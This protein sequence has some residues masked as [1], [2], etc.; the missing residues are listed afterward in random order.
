MFF[1]P[2]PMSVENGPNFN[3]YLILRE[4]TLEL[5]SDENKNEKKKLPPVSVKF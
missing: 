3:S 2:M 5:F 1:G 4:N